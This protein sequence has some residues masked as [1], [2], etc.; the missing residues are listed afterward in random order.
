[1]LL[2]ERLE[3]VEGALH[4]A[5]DSLLLCFDF[6]APRVN[7]TAQIAVDK[8]A[9]GA[10]AHANVGLL[11]IGLGLEGVDLFLHQVV[12]NAV[13]FFRDNLASAPHCLFRPG[14][15]FVLRRLFANVEMNP[16]LESLRFSD[17]SRRFLGDTVVERLNGSLLFL[18]EGSQG[19]VAL[20]FETVQFILDFALDALE[21]HLQLAFVALDGARTRI[22]VNIGDDILRKIEH[23]FQMAWADVE[24]QAQPARHALDVPDMTDRRGQLDVPHAFAAD[25]AWRHLDAAFVADDALVADAFVLAAGALP[26]TRGAKDTLAEKAVALWA[27]RAVVDRL[28]L[29]HFAVA[30]LADAFGRGQ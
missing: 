4:L 14:Q 9:L 11:L 8:F 23:A 24:Q 12:D 28:R 26:V 30:P 6:V 19:R 7:L 5:A 21:A 3:V 29:G 20:G 18:V 1:M 13:V 25:A 16:G 15:E 27:Q 17:D 22:L 2:F 10:N